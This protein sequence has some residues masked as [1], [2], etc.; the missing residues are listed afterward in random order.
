MIEGVIEPSLV[1]QVKLCL[2][3]YLGATNAGTRISRERITKFLKYCQTIESGVSPIGFK[4]RLSISS[5]AFVNGLSSHSAEMDDGYRFGMSHPGAPIFSALLP[6]VQ[7]RPADIQL[8][9]KAVIVGYEVVTRLS[10]AM[11]PSH[12]AK[13]Y[14]PTATCG[15]V[16]VA[17]SVATYLEASEEELHNA[18][19][20]AATC[21]G[22]S[23]K[24]IE[25]KSD[26]KP[27]NI[28]NAVSVGI[29]AAYLAMSGFKVPED[30]FSGDTGFFSVMSTKPN[31]DEL[32]RVESKHYGIMNVYFKPYAACRHAHA[33]IEAALEI[34]TNPSFDSSLIEKVEV[35]IYESVIGKHDDTNI[36]GVNSAKMSIPFSVALALLRGSASIRDFQSESICNQTLL[37]LC[38][39]VEVIGDSDLSKLVPVVRPAVVTVIQKNGIRVEQRV[40]LPKGEPESAMTH[41]EAENK[42]TELSTYSGIANEKIENFLNGYWDQW[43]SVNAKLEQ[44]L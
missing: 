35:R 14:H 9:Y 1:E 4:E 6:I 12:Y 17:A 26:L 31:L 24:A 5:A 28:A 36:V 16:G 25:G 41:L 34:R 22:G 40:D 30:G 19:V 42:F 29:N 44:L 27:H 2:L 18:I 11:Q 7:S 10:A 37:R 32:M 33:S 8:F 23:L 39:I 3:D 13:G 38:K 21:S 15:A 43:S 20:A